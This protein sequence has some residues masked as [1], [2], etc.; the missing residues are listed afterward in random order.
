MRFVLLALPILL[1][2]LPAKADPISDA[3]FGRPFSDGVVTGG[4]FG[5]G[6]NDYYG[7]ENAMRS[8]ASSG[9]ARSASGSRRRQ[10]T[11]LAPSSHQPVVARPY[12]P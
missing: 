4:A 11:H 9:P 7:D 8:H 12:R 1:T 2:V 6:G 10:H 5:A 3:L